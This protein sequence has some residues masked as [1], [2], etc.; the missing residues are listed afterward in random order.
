MDLNSIFVNNLEEN[1]TEDD[2]RDYF[3]DCGSIE[4]V[5]NIPLN[6]K[7]TLRND[8]VTGMMFSYIQFTDAAAVEDALLLSDGM[9]RGR[10]IKVHKL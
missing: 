8:K 5:L 4:K 6:K 9:I 7:I 2:L 10:K 1:T 3:K